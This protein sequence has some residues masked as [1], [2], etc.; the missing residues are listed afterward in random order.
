MLQAAKLNLSQYFDVG[1]VEELDA[2]AR[3]MGLQLPKQY[4]NK[5]VSYAEDLRPQTAKLLRK[6]QELDLQLYE[7]AK[8]ISAEHAARVSNV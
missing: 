3:R 1:I 6:S 5:G 2:F 7:F 8:R 4:L